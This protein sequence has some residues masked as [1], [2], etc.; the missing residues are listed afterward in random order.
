[1]FTPVEARRLTRRPESDSIIVSQLNF[2]RW[3]WNYGVFL[4]IFSNEKSLK[5]RSKFFQVEKMLLKN[6][7]FFVFILIIELENP[8][9][10]ALSMLNCILTRS[11]SQFRVFYF[12]KFQFRIFTSNKIE[13]EFSPSMTVVVVVESL[14]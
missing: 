8:L 9:N 11:A 13:H 5:M 10:R 7:F 4:S 12:R 3:K 14:S 2:Q 6:F 1:M